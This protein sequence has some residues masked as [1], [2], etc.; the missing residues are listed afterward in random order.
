[1]EGYPVNLTECSS[2]EQIVSFIPGDRRVIVIIDSNVKKRYGNYFP[3]PQIEIEASES[4]KTLSSVEQICHELMKLGADRD[5]FILVVGGGITTDIGGFVASV[6]YRGV[7]FAFVPTTLLSQVD[8][9][10][11]GKNGVNT[12]GYKNIIGVI[13][14]PE[15]TI[16]C[17]E[18]LNTL[19]EQHL[20][21]GVAEMLK[22]FIIG[23][24]NLYYSAI[25]YLSKNRFNNPATLQ[26]YALSAAKIKASIVSKDLY[27]RGERKLLNLGH[28]FAHAIEKHSSTA[29]GEAVATGI[30]LAARLSVKLSVTDSQTAITIIDNLHNLGFDTK[31]NLTAMQMAGAIAKDKKKSH[32]NVSFILIEKIG[33]CISY[34]IEITRL[35]E[36]LNDLS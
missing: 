32:T 24:Q 13:K 36:V 7:K 34:P 27:E 29:H 14:Q 9:A 10:I 19:S 15:F 5:T 25:D 1:M 23:N 33:K 2:P 28:T 8:A 3:Y 6:Y 35:E 21:C 31:T 20:K 11:G 30:A 18:F 26:P 17:P 12:E 16:I 4:S 22:T